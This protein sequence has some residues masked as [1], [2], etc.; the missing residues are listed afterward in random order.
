[1]TFR[2][3]LGWRYDSVKLKLSLYSLVNYLIQ[4]LFLNYPK[5]SLAATKL[6]LWFLVMSRLQKKYILLKNMSECCC[7]FCVQ[8]QRVIGCQIIISTEIF[9]RTKTFTVFPIERLQNSSFKQPRQIIIFWPKQ[10]KHPLTPQDWSHAHMWPCF[11]L[12]LITFHW[13]QILAFPWIRCSF[14]F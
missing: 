4:T 11:G 5:L 12:W 14:I 13:N 1:M 6:C 10:A 9:S 3:I 2:Y 8:G 7:V